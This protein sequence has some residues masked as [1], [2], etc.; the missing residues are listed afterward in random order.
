MK[1]QD[2]TYYAKNHYNQP[3]QWELNS[4]EEQN[5]Q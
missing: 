3:Q 2:K 5:E 4:Q 1:A